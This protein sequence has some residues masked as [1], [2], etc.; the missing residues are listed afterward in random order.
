MSKTQYDE[1]TK[2][3]WIQSDADGD[4]LVD[5]I[6]WTK[7]LKAGEFEGKALKTINV[8]FTNTEGAEYNQHPLAFSKIQ[9][10]VGSLKSPTKYDGE[11]VSFDTREDISMSTS[12]K[13][14]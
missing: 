10:Y 11:D 7:L 8:V 5:E 4:T 9:T 12:S 13:K 6:P 1:K 14:S 3:L 2:T